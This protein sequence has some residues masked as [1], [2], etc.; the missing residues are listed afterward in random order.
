MRSALL[1]L[2]LVTGLGLDACQSAPVMCVPDGSPPCECTPGDSRLC[3]TD[4]GVQGL[5][6]CGNSGTWTVCEPFSDDVT[7]S[8]DATPN[9]VHLF[10]QDGS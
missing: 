5:E 4:G 3:T 9:D 8:Y 1:A 6:A 2:L 7:T 10:S